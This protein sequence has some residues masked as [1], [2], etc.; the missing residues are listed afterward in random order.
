MMRIL[1]PLFNAL[2]RFR[3]DRRGSATVEFALIFPVFILLFSSGFESGVLTVRQTMLERSTAMAVRNVQIST[4]IPPTPDQLKRNI[5]N[6]ALVIPDCM[7]VIHIEMTR[8]SMTDWALPTGPV[9]CIDRDEE[10]E[11]VV[12]FTPGT[13]NDLMFVRVCAVFRP[14]FPTSGLGLKL[15]RVNSSDYALVASSFFVAE[16]A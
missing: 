1:A 15:P 9:R 14:M 16:P 2:R 5:C 6:L 3:A 12:S 4:K 13:S 10:I 8:I 11:P 7:E